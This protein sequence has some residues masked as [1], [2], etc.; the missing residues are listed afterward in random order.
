V[1]IRNAAALGI[2][3]ARRR[4]L[5]LADAALEAV[6]TGPAIRRA[7]RLDGSDLLVQARRHPLPTGR[8]LLVAVGKCAAAASEALGAILG[9]RLHDGVVVDAVEVPPSRRVAP[10]RYFAGTHP[11]PSERNVAAAGAAVRLLEGAGPDDLA[12]AV[13]SGGGSTLLCLPPPGLSW[14]WEAELFDALTRAGATITELNTVRKHASL[15]RGGFLARHA[16]P[17]RLISLVFSDVPGA[18]IEFVASGPTVPD[19]T[20]LDDA[21][22]VLERY[23]LGGA[24][25]ARAL[26][27]TPKEPAWFA[28]HHAELIV[29]TGVA[30]EAMAARARAIGLDPSIED[31]AFEGEARE[32]AV[33]VVGALHT[34]PRG[35]AL[36][37]GGE[38]TVT[39]RGTGRGGRNAELALAALPHMPSGACVLALAT[40]GRDNAEW[41][42]ALADPALR[43]E[44]ARLGVDPAA[45]LEANDSYG[46]FERVGG[47]LDT[48]PTGANVAD[49]VIAVRD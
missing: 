19:T 32:V 18:G 23:G 38:S 4:A 8:L 42:G 45:A 36:L 10:L 31:A 13:V 49:L 12:L 1:I 16:H 33:R 26:V 35:A 21:R 30:L 11:R 3:D 40:D 17:A 9:E 22:A 7:V 14:R 46:F 20:T 34:V 5:A 39:V 6:A 28:R 25:E 15:A 2:T 41:A 48:G 47:C 44:A 37:W 24:P 43:D 29:S 27:E